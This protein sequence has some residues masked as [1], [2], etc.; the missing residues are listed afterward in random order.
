M[1]NIINHNIFNGI[2]GARPSYAPKY[3]ILHNDAGSMN[4]E[5]YISWLEDRYNNGKADLGF[6][7]YYIDRY[8]I[9]RVENTFNGTWSAAHPDANLYSLSYE[10][11][12][13][14]STS[15]EEFIENENMVLM[16][17][18]EDMTFYEDTPNYDN[19]KFHNEFSSTSCPARSLELHGG[20]NDSLRD[21]V[22]EKIKYYQSLGSTVQEMLDNDTVQEYG[23]L[24]SIDGWQYRDENGLVKNDWKQ[25]EDKWY[26]FDDTGYIICNDWFKNPS[27]EKW[28]W[29]HPDGVMATGWQLINDK[30]YFFNED[31][32][33]VEG[34][35]Q[36]KDKVYYLK[37]ND[38]DMVS[39]ECRQIDGEWYYFNE[40]GERLEK[41]NITVDEQGTIHF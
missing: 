21:Y 16:Q 22:I 30:W 8:S 38:G 23:W 14:F 37:A 18:A 40:N 3:Y 28:Y 19:I 6:A 13:Q 2:A 9:A 39:R 36:Y 5:S 7:H 33:M 32:E 29:L 25:V 27:N 35:L 34:W 4:A 26:R 31:G 15:D 24:K 10:V 20:D 1:V 17:M 11:C 12:Q 41:A